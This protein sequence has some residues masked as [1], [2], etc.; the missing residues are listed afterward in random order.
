MTVRLATRDDIEAIL[1]MAK[2][3]CGESDYGME[4]DEQASRDYLE[5]LFEHLDEVAIFVNDDV[6]AATIATISQDWCKRPVCYVE[7]LFLMPNAR[8]SGIARELIEQVILFAA[9]HNCSHVFSTATA[10]MGE[11][12]ERMF[13]NLFRKY[14]F[15]GCGT[16]IVKVM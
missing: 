13:I 10:G 5:L 1:I 4:Y 11:R 15:A 3:F 6:T 16:T 7:K 9:K 12:V 8:G 14:G 2:F